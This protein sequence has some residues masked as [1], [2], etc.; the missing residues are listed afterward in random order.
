MRNDF[1]RRYESQ[2]DPLG[3][4]V[5]EPPRKSVFGYECN[6]CGRQSEL[7]YYKKDAVCGVKKCHGRMKHI[8]TDT[9]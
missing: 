9:L 7:P 4:F 3:S 6:L 2:K 8:Y 5:P 1:F